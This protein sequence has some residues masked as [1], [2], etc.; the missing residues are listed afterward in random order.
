M[1]C[2]IPYG[3]YL[4]T[5]T[6]R[7]SIDNIRLKFEYKYKNYDFDHRQTVTSVE[8]ISQHLDN[9]FFAGLDVS[10]SRLDFFRIGSYSRTCTISALDWS[11]A[12]MIGRYCFDNSCK[13]IAPEA[14]M[15]F[16][17]N[18][19]PID[20]I[21]RIVS[22]LQGSALSFAVQRF[23]V[24][25]DYALPRAEVRL[26]EDKAKGYRLFRELGAVTEYQGKRS[27]HSAMKLYDKTKESEL[28]VPVTRCE[29][30]IERCVYKSVADVFPDL[31][32]Y[33]A[34]QL[35]LAFSALPFEVK[36]CILYPDLIEELRNSCN[37][38]TFQ[39]HI[40]SVR[41]YGNKS[42]VPTNWLEIDCFIQSALTTY[43]KGVTI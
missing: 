30:T 9:Q 18:K 6:C 14:V 21:Q 35:D 27:K 34:E 16:N 10:W 23:D 29:I 22:L 26:I 39:K 5:D 32:Y 37:R 31:F 7:V 25:F 20:V 4:D 17:P 11:F 36:A 38:H 1:F 42:L 28:S 43:T 41:K 2:G 24:A 19:V 8:L 33:G 13:Q 40:G 3:L 15:D 12:V